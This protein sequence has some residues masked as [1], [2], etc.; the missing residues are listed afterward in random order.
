MRKY[1]ADLECDNLTDEEYITLRKLLRRKTNDKYKVIITGDRCD[2][3]NLS[4][5][6]EY[7]E[8]GTRIGTFYFSNKMELDLILAAFEGLFYQFFRIGVPERI[9]G[10][11]V[12]DLIF[13]NMEEES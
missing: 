5:L 10:G 2:Y 4:E 1:F 7:P 13:E 12:D 9:G 8:R 6:A 3:D 11:V